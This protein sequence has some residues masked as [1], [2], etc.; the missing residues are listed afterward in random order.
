M[1]KIPETP[2][3]LLIK[4]ITFIQLKQNPK[5]GTS[6]N[7]IKQLLNQIPILLIKLTKSNSKAYSTNPKIKKDEFNMDNYRLKKWIGNPRVDF[8]LSSLHYLCIVCSDY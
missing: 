1:N 4:T 7:L 6:K 8:S 2:T 5:L 3:I